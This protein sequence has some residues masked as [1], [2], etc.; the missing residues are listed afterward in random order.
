MSNVI[1]FLERMG[2]DA[3]LRYAPPAE[4]ERAAEAA[5]LERRARTAIAT[6]DGRRLGELLGARAALCCIVAVPEDEEEKDGE[7][8]KSVA[9][10]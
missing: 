4:V 7:D 9:S 6:G 3:T 8:K 5:R 1:E 2:A 10:I